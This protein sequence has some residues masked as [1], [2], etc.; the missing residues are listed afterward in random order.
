MDICYFCGLP[1]TSKEHVPPKSFFPKKGNKDYRR[2]LIKVPSCD[3]H[4]SD[5]SKDDEYVRALLVG[6]SKTI[7]S[8]KNKDLISLRDSVIRS[9]TRNPSI[10]QLVLRNPTPPIRLGTGAEIPEKVL[11]DYDIERV[12]NI[13][14]SIS[15]GIYF[16]HKRSTWTGQVEVIP[17]FLISEKAD[18]D[19]RRPIEELSSLI[20]EKHSSGDNKDIFYYELS[21]FHPESH[22]QHSIDFCLYQEFKVTCIFY[23]NSCAG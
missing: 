8:S 2:N 3:L 20:Q 10:I 19:E 23:R 16:H 12:K 21:S 22:P 14:E 18:P 4:N 7:N 13:F 17:H 6:V 1:A 9:M 15:K 11:V 5:K